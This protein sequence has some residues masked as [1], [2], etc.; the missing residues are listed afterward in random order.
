MM[1]AIPSANQSGK[2]DG[3]PAPR[4]VMLSAVEVEAFTD[5]LRS[6]LRARPRRRKDPGELRGAAAEQL[7]CGT[8]CAECSLATSP[9]HYTCRVCKTKW[10][11]GCYA[12]RYD[13][14]HPLTFPGL[15]ATQ[16]VCPPCARHSDNPPVAEA[17]VRVVGTKWETM[18]DKVESACQAGP[19]KRRFRNRDREERALFVALL[20]GL[21]SA[22]ETHASAELAVLYLPR[23]VLTKGTSVRRAVTYI[24]EVPP[25]AQ[26]GQRT[27]WT[28]DQRL[29]AAVSNAIELPKSGRL[30]GILDRE[31]PPA[32]P[33]DPDA[34]HKYFP[35][36]PETCRNEDNVVQ[37]WMR[38]YAPDVDAQVFTKS[39]LRAWAFASATS[40][41][42]ELGW[43]G[44]MIKAIIQTDT[45]VWDRF[46]AFVARPPNKWRSAAHAHLLYRSTTGWMIPAGQKWRPIAAPT[47]VRRAASRALMH[48]ARASINSYAVPRGQ[49]GMAKDDHILAYSVLP[50]AAL[51]AHGSVVIADRSMSFQTLNRSAVLDALNDYAR[52]QYHDD[53]L[54][55]RSAL[56][57]AILFYAEHDHF[58]VP[59]KRTTVGFDEVENLI[60]VHGLAQGCTSSPNFEA[61]TLAHAVGRSPDT[62]P[63][64]SYLVMQAH[65][66][67]TVSSTSRT[68][69]DLS[70]PD[71]S[72]AGGEYNAN[73]GVATGR[74]AEEAVEN[75][76]VAS[77]RPSPTLWGRPLRDFTT[78]YDDKYGTVN[79]R[80]D[81]ILSLH[82]KN[83]HLA[84]RTACKIGGPCAMLTH[85]LRATPPSDAAALDLKP[86][87]RLWNYLLYRLALQNHDSAMALANTRPH[88]DHVKI[89]GRAVDDV[90]T[91]IA[92]EGTALAF[93]GVQAL[94]GRDAAVEV[95]SER[96]GMTKSELDEHTAQMPE[97]TRRRDTL[98]AWALQEQPD[99]DIVRAA[100]ESRA[101]CTP[102][103]ADM[104]Y[105]AR[106]AIPYALA[107][108]STLELP[109]SRSMYGSHSV[110]T[111][112][113]ACGGEWGARFE[114]ASSCP[115]PPYTADFRRR[116]NLV[117]SSLVSVAK[118]CGTA[119]EEHDARIPTLPSNQRPADWL[120][121]S[122]TRK[123]KHW[124]C[125]LTIVQ[126]ENLLSAVTKKTKRY[127][128][129]LK[130]ARLRLSIFAVDECGNF[131]GQTED[132]M[133][134]WKTTL[135]ANRRAAG[136][137]PTNATAEIRSAVGLIFA[138]AM[139]HWWAWHN[140]KSGRRPMRR[141]R[142]SRPVIKRA[143]S[144]SPSSANESSTLHSRPNCGRRDSAEAVAPAR[145]A[146]QSVHTVRRTEDVLADYGF[147]QIPIPTAAQSAIAPPPL[148]RNQPTAA[149]CARSAQQHQQRQSVIEG[150]GRRHQQTSRSDDGKNMDEEI[151]ATAHVQNAR[152]PAATDSAER[153]R[154]LE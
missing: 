67:V 12:G 41:G 58:Y 107:I 130:N 51:R 129:A 106:A 75:G 92:Y 27:R 18:W 36:Q 90:K 8:P 131:A 154:V 40:S 19:A 50:Q 146:Q 76:I 35:N 108:S 79:K 11:P 91:H 109:Y 140:T 22:A 111:T 80:V 45:V 102:T 26:S 57:A 54:G 62:P 42:G 139:A 101:C 15:S 113:C 122:H 151:S 84:V 77:A 145:R 89:T 98:W 1:P 141:P 34:I 136:L 74:G 100:R 5:I 14:G 3:T 17:L 46:A 73:K 94:M 85:A 134:R 128:V 49:V 4:E 99:S 6:T 43:T 25:E 72:A 23:F 9:I 150:T 149:C 104:T 47:F 93:K 13:P 82:S 123:A 64:R 135:C 71:C 142:V 86:F 21:I 56:L 53:T 52:T 87:D 143:R 39:D 31:S 59:F 110:Y 127:A 138:H 112:T 30:I 70:L 132:V 38:T 69:A 29:E 124:C 33:R 60:D 126:P 125:D 7:G 24:P 153:R 37:H 115:A 118:S 10:H 114:H 61:I 55:V 2:R 81:K 116:H 48:K 133:K 68:A 121:E 78:W 137:Q 97:A 88:D 148:G 103:V 147:S 32:E 144:N 119:A 28:D 65:D 63:D 20:D 152:R 120:E 117:V 96:D 44:E 66:D 16:V 83:P 95:L 105:S